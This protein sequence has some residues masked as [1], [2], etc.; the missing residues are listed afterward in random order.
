MTH[1]PSVHP[2]W[3]P[4][5]AQVAH[6]NLTQFIRSVEVSHGT[7]LADYWALDRWAVEYPEAFWT[8]LWDFAAVV[9]ETRGHTVL[10][11]GER[12][13]GAKWFPEARMNFAENLLR[14]NDDTVALLFWGEEQ[15][16]RRLTHRELYDSVSQLAQVFRAM[17]V[18]VGDRVVGFIPNMPEAIIAMLASASVGAV[19]SSCSPDYGVRGA[20]D[21]FGQ[22]KPKVLITAD[23]YF[24]DGKT[25]D[26]LARIAEI[27]RELPSLEKVLVVPYVDAEPDISELRNASLLPDVLA[28]HSASAIAFEQ[29]PFAHPLYIMFSSGTTGVPKCIVHSAG[30]T[31]LQHLKEHLLH[32]DMHPGERLFYYTTCSWMMWNWLVSGLAA[33]ATLLLYDGSP[34]RLEG[35]ILFDYADAEDMS[36]FGTSA[37]YIEALA[38]NGLQPIK[39]HRLER[40][41]CMLSTGSPL[42]P[43][44]FDFVYSKV[45]HDLQ[46]SSI[47]GGTDIVSCFVLGNPVLPVWR[48]EIQCRGL[49]LKVEVFDDD[50][51][52][53]VGGK[54]ELVCGA[55]FPCMPTGFWNDHDDS[56]YR[57]AYF[58]Q[59]PGVWCQGDYAEITDH[60]GFVIHGRS[61]ATLNPGGVRIG[62]AEI[63][64]Q[65]EQVEEVVE[66]IVIGQQWL[67]DTRV[68]LFVQL[69]AGVKLDEDLVNRIKTQI[70]QNTTPRHVPAKVLQVDDIPRT[71]TG[72]IVELAVRHI[73]HDRAVKNVEA[74][75][76]PEALDSFRNLDELRH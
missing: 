26:S 35:N 45:K 28:S 44:S 14:R 16:K 19:W 18:G 69:K 54:G 72:K 21:R 75:A 53:M 58:E 38:K 22:V 46:L 74:L 30:G 17:G 57:A 60:N 70:R 49:G 40:L 15:V 71:K 33:E 37:K 76:N 43:E 9:A 23:G 48:G 34:F 13:P 1:D 52:A 4:T 62:S 73:V 12:M 32:T 8:S 31:L 7:R 65:V 67:N 25:H 2:L 68:V 24:Y 47:S 5:S 59:L 50:G 29:L 20:L 3:K 10:E 27:E 55:P 41:R 63:Y 51:K 56:K 11:D 36:V 64:R 61:D 39:S 42:A 6:A 66:S